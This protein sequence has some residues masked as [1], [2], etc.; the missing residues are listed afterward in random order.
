[1]GV[2]GMTTRIDPRLRKA[3]KEFRIEKRIGGGGMGDVYLATDTGLQGK[4]AIKVLSPNLAQDPAIVD[5]FINEARIGAMLQH[6]NIIKVVGVRQVQDVHCMIMVYAEGEDLAERLQRLGR[7]SELQ[8]LEICVPVLRAL[9]CAHDHKIVHRDLK[10]SNIRVDRYGNVVVL[11]FGIARARDFAIRSHTALGER[12]GTPLYMSPEQIEG[13]EVDERSD[14]YS[15]GVI[16]YEMVAGF[17]PFAADSAHGIYHSHLAENPTPLAELVPAVSAR[18]SDA[19]ARLLRKEPAQRYATAADTLQ[20]FESLRAAAR[21][22]AAGQSTRLDSEAW[23]PVQLPA[24]IV[25]RQLTDSQKQVLELV[26]G[27]RKAGEIS[28]AT[29]LRDERVIAVLE[30][31]R[32]MG[33][34]QP[35]PEAERKLSPEID[36]ASS[37][38]PP[39]ATTF[40]SSVKRR[41]YWIAGLALLMAAVVLPFSFRG[42]R[43]SAVLLLDAS[44]YAE[45]T[46]RDEKGLVVGQEPTPAHLV[47]GPGKFVIEFRYRSEVRRVELEADPGHTVSHRE[48]FLP[49]QDWRRILELNLEKAVTEDQ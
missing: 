2:D 20:V 27:Q 44:P 30:E 24:T 41:N 8:A 42:D 6:P 7:L 4:W 36:T 40:L 13:K 11:D 15:L 32:E 29:G 19:V 9:V 43:A 48:E 28:E 10:P 12:L 16:A 1:M 47:V 22:V 5:R 26:D 14:L 49:S 25:N 37:G 18:Y 17:N 21:R 35:S 45:V 34:V 46:V 3:L 39:T 31:L 38:R 23:L 33:M